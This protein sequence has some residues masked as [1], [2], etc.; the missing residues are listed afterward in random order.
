MFKNDT[1]IYHKYLINLTSFVLWSAIKMLY[2]PTSIKLD[3]P[4]TAFFPTLR[5]LTNKYTI[6]FSYLKK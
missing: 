6:F 3:L 1:V 5:G 4:L 2:Y